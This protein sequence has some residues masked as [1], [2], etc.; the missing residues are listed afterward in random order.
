[1]AVN[2]S[3]DAVLQNVLPIASQ[4][5]AQAFQK[6]QAAK[7]FEYGMAGQVQQQ[8]WQ[9]AENIAQRGFLGTQAQPRSRPSD[10]DAGQSDQHANDALQIRQIAST[11]G[12]EAADRAL[13]T[14][15]QEK[16]IQFRIAARASSPA[17]LPSRCRAADIA[18]QKSEGALDQQTCKIRW[19]DGTYLLMIAIGRREC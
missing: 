5:A 17:S 16:D 7:A 6:N 10:D 19:P 18:F 11:E 13:Q 1:M 8:G 2:A 12:I 14:A 4:D 15:L 9:T 3:Q